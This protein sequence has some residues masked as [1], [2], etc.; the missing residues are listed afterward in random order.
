MQTETELH[1]QHVA[2]FE[3]AKAERQAEIAAAELIAERGER[4]LELFRTMEPGIAR[5]AIVYLDQRVR[6]LEQDG[7]W[8]TGTRRAVG[9]LQ[10][11]ERRRG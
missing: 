5:D 6:D 10:A 11:I 1:D 2:E 4:A 7:A 3:S 9:E 8:A